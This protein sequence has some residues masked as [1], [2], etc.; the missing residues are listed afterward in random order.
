MSRTA[1]ILRSDV[2]SLE[3]L[4]EGMRL[5]GTVRNV[6]DFGAF[7]DIG[8]E[9][10]GMVH[11]S[12]LGADYF[13]FDE[14]RHEL[15]GERT[16]KRYQ[17]TNR[18]TVQ[19]SRVDLDARRIDLRLVDGPGRSEKG[20]GGKG[21]AAVKSDLPR[22]PFTPSENQPTA[23]KN[24]KTAQPVTTPEKKPGK[25]IRLNESRYAPVVSR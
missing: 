11:I 13:E 16:G 10:P 20:R 24:Q 5:K 23:T 21:R 2:L 17:L 19:V 1:V 4:A 7:V 14:A 22:T 12:D 6:V 3:N 9:R 15:R 25:D 8:A 18:V